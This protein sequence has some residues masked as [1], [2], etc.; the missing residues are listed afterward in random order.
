L[1]NTSK[2]QFGPFVIDVRERVLRRDGQPVAL[3]PKAFDVLAALVEQPGRLLSKQEL[4]EKV[5]PDTFVEE[6][7]LAYNVFA[8]RKTLGDTADNAQYIETVP[9]RGY[10][11]TATVTPVLRNDGRSALEDALETGSRAFGEEHSHSIVHNSFTQDPAPPVRIA[12][13]VPNV[14]NTVLPF[15]RR[16]AARRYQPSADPNVPLEDRASETSGTER[17]QALRSFSSRQRWALVVGAGVISAAVYF[18]VQSRYLSTDPLRAV[19]LTSLP[20]VVRSP[21]L[22]PDGNYVA[23]SWTGPKQDNPDIYVQQIGAG[24]H[25]RLTRDPNNDYSPSWSPDG[26]A[27]AFLR[28]GPD[29]DTE[30]W[31][32]A[33]LGGSERKIAV[34]KPKR[35]SYRPISLTWCPDS[36]CILV[37]DSPRDGQPDAV[38]AV[39]LDTGEKRQLTNP[40]HPAQ[41]DA[42]PS[43][44]PD[45]RSL[46]F[47]RDVTPFSGQF[48]RLPLKGQAVPDGDPVR[49]TST[50]GAGQSSWTADSREILFSNRGGLW[51]LDALKGGAPARLPFVGQDGLTPVL[52]RTP[53]GRQ[54]LVYVRSFV[55]RNIWRIDTISPGAPASS[56]PALAIASTRSDHI[57]N[58]S[59]DGRRVVFTSDRSGDAEVWTADLDGSN[60]V[61]LTSMAILPGFPRWSPD[62]GLITFHGDP[63]GHADVLVVPAS[64]GKPRI[65]T[66]N[67]PDDGFPSFSR[68]G[69]W[70]YLCSTRGD[71]RRISKVPVSGGVEVPVTDNVGTISLES[72]DGRDLYYIEAPQQLSTSLWR[73]PLAGGPPVK[74]LDGVMLGNFDVIEKGIY[75]VDRF[76]G[77]AGVFFT[78]RP[79]GETRLQY[80]DFV[81]QRSTTV[82]HNLGAVGFGL[83]ASRDG[84]TIF[85][86]R[87]D[88]SV[89]ELM[90]VDNFR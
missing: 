63:Q 40:Q 76:A 54:R 52:S 72:H 36:A 47:R 19:P 27:I 73:L 29:G 58:L 85:Y 1:E 50:L 20:G 88:A 71:V 57:P 34:I 55:D 69:K 74:V 53:D 16:D 46:I 11:F 78:D 66:T 48:Y 14:E 24:T 2:S 68:D 56:A 33:P 8:L 41:G 21:S 3:T 17:S 45:G 80:F 62:G 9:K 38:F 77:E 42:D 82:A 84:R 23:F 39:D 67:T 43:V 22:S 70:I 31:R 83:S 89:D 25:H 7:N 35:S 49:L 65:L 18:G 87:V 75:Y 86:S 13:A 37:I 28:R 30:V 26:R 90:L 4:L 6:S 59:P 64:G 81:T 44:S 5:W 12:T 51:R 61:K 60:A 10:R 15:P 32:I 79:G